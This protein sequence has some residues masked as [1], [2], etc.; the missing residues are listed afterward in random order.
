MKSPKFVLAKVK[1]NTTAA[2]LSLDKAIDL[3]ALLVAQLISPTAGSAAAE[4]KLIVDA[5]QSG[6]ASIG[7]KR[8]HRA[9]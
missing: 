1:P 6:L 5:E 4:E 2:K 8:L 9:E 7:R 3:R